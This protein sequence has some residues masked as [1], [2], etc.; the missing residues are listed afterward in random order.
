MLTNNHIMYL[1]DDDS[2]LKPELLFLVTSSGLG[3]QYP[4]DFR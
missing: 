2:L 3:H 1:Q 4:W